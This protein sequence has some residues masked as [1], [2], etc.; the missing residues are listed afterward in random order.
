[1]AISER[2]YYF[3]DHC[4]T[5]QGSGLENSPLS[6]FMQER[7]FS[8]QSLLT[9]LPGEYDGPVF[10]EP[11]VSGNGL[12]IFCT[13]DGGT[14]FDSGERN[15]PCALKGNPEYTELH[16]FYTP[17][18]ADKQK[19]EAAFLHLLR[20]AVESCLSLDGGLS[21]HASCVVLDGKALL[22]TGPSGA[23]KST[24]AASWLNQTEAFLVSGDRPHLKVNTDGGVRVFGVPWD[25]KEQCFVQDS[26][27]VA[28]I[29]EVRQARSDRLRCLRKG[30]FLR[31]LLQQA[32]LPMWDDAAKFSTLHSLKRM[33]ECVP[34]YRLFCTLT[35]ESVTL[36]SDAL[37]AGLSDLVLPEDNDMKIKDGFILKNVVGEWLVMPTGENVKKFEGA[38]IL[39]DVSAYI[40]KALERPVSK[41]D[42]LQDIIA[43]YSVEMQ[44]ARDDLDAFLERLRALDLL[45]EE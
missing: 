24:Q 26:Y 39:N 28:G 19:G 36:V 4:L 42:L 32:F 31:L 5:V 30:Q 33:T 37:F 41:T 27:P 18:H 20:L 44:E 14:L 11:A 29:I 7:E 8:T 38:I 45:I 2:K 12:R 3:A 40:W 34:C 16:G 15:T 25:G 1:M 21:L 10:A 35:P 13:A 17:R 6:L 22:F 23:G 43:E 9:I